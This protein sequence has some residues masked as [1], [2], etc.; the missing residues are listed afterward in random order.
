M[1][2]EERDLV[3]RSVAEGHPLP[4]LA[5]FYGGGL[6]IE[7]EPGTRFRCSDHG[8]ATVGHIVED[9]SGQPL[10]H[11][12]REHVFEPLGMTDTTLDRD[13]VDVTRLATGYT[14]TS[15]GAAVAPSRDYVTAGAASA[16]QYRPDPRLPGGPV[17]RRAPRCGRGPTAPTSRARRTSAPARWR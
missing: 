16:Y 14:L 5:R 12:Y 8:F 10:A 9:V 11:Y 15:R 2:S 13:E 1:M 7:A 3:N 4:S 6:R 17:R